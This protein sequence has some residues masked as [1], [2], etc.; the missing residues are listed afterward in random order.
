MM[1][2]LGYGALSLYSA[3]AH[4]AI[5]LV[6]VLRVQQRPKLPLERSE[7][8][9]SVPKTTP[10]VFDLDPRG[11]PLPAAADADAESQSFVPQAAASLLPQQSKA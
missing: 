10:A 8:F 2:E 1:R 3:M 11:E 7:R 4:A 9:V 5:A 6:M